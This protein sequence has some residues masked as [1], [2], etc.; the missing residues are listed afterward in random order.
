MQALD[1]ST[2]H[3]SLDFNGRQKA[4]RLLSL[5]QK[6]PIVLNLPIWLLAIAA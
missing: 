5:C 1:I 2:K 3:A 4:G 6:I